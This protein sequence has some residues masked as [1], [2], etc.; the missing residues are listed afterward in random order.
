[1][2][3]VLMKILSHDGAEKKYKNAEGFQ[4]SHFYWLFSSDTMAVKGVNSDIQ[5]RETR[6]KKKRKKRQQNR[7]NLNPFTAMMSLQNDQV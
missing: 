3:C 6:R 7:K 2:L 1:M 5:K 4:I